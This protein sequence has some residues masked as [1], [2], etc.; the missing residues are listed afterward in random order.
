MAQ[1]LSAGPVYAQVS[2]DTATIT[3]P[4]VDAGDNIIIGLTWYTY[5]PSPA[6]LV[7]ITI[8]GESNATIHGSPHVPAGGDGY[9][10]TQWASLANVTTGGT[11]TI[12]VT[13]TPFVASSLGGAFALA[14]AGGAAA[15]ILDVSAANDGNSNT[16][17][18]SLT[19]TVANDL[20]VA[21]VN[22][23][24]GEP[25]AGSGYTLFDIPNV[26]I[27]DSSEYKLDAGAAGAKTVNFTT[28]GAGLGF[29][30]NAA[31]FK[32]GAAASGF[33]ARPYYDMIGQQRMGS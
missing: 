22:S 18:V 8:S 2:F 28:P 32:P 16:P 27:Y 21:V 4:N 6:T 1:T 19:T 30:I 17:S 10:T 23:N 14:V 25:S 15:S 3:L 9:A 26:Y 7:S 13:W 33:F 11:K 5:S 24:D 29:T 12:T 31:A 20:I